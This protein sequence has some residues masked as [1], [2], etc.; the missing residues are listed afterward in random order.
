MLGKRKE[1]EDENEELVQILKKII[2]S[3]V[4]QMQYCYFPSLLI[5]PLSFNLEINKTVSKF[6]IIN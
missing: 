4:S 6:R 2:P 1:R 3:N 5:F